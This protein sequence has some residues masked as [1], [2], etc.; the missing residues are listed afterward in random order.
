[1]YTERH[2]EFHC[3]SFSFLNTKHFIYYRSA[4]KTEYRIILNVTGYL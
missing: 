1:M 2:Y 3:S 4:M